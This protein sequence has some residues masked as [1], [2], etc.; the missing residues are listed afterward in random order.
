MYLLD[1]R[2]VTAVAFIE[3]FDAALD[4]VPLNGFNEWV[5]QR[6]LGG[7]SPS[8]WP[9]VVA[10]VRVP[11]IYDPGMGIGRISSE[12]DLDLVEDTI[13]LIEEFHSRRETG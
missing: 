6:I 12:F 8:R 5:S 13:S 2:Y 9:Y 3:G 4:G 1:D 10:A 7:S 11:S